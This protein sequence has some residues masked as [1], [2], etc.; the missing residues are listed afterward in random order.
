MVWCERDT[1]GETLTTDLTTLGVVTVT[2]Y[3]ASPSVYPL[4]MNTPSLR[5]T[6]GT[7]S[8]KLSDTHIVTPQTITS[9]KVITIRKTGSVL[10]NRSPPGLREVC[11]DTV[12]L[13]GAVKINTV[14]S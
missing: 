11:N 13:S 12:T 10:L 1:V 14:P 2:P 5:G 3:T 8:D 7:P 9:D 4:T 6:D